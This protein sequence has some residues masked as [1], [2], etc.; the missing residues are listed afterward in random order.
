MYII[1]KIKNTIN[2][3]Y[4]NLNIRSDIKEK[5]KEENINSLKKIIGDSIDKEE[6]ILPGLGVI[7]EIIWKS[8]NDSEKNNL[9]K[10][11][12]DNIKK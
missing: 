4:M 5:L 3:D 10:V 2:G 12:I 11:F 7:F 9:V 8:I 6:L 1:K